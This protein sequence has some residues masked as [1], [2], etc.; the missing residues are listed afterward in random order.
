[1]N[2]LLVKHRLLDKGMSL[3]ELARTTRLPY[4]RVIR[5]LNGYRDPREDEV[6]AIAGVLGIRTDE[7]K[8]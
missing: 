7:L 2:R 6:R 5:I 1:M 3:I 4:D 8:N